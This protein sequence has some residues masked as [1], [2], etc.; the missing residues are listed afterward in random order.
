[1]LAEDKL[2]IVGHDHRSKV[3]VVSPLPLGKLCFLNT[4]EV[5][6]LVATKWDLGAVFN[7]D[8]IVIFQG[9]NLTLDVLTCYE[10]RSPL[11]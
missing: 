4:L 9:L 1:M 7:R 3:Y 8:E 11:F 2:H 5:L 10:C 6:M